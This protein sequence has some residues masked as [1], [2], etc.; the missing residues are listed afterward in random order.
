M[1]GMRPGVRFKLWSPK[2]TNRPDIE[3]PALLQFLGT[4]SILSAF[5]FLVFAVAIVIVPYG[6]NFEPEPL[7]ALYVATL[8]F[9]LPIGIFYT[10]MV[11]SPLS[12]WVISIHTVVLG[13][14]TIAGEGFLGQLEISETTRISASGAIMAIVLGW[15][16]GSPKMRFYYA[17]ISGKPIPEDLRSR[18]DELRGGVRLN[19]RFRAALEWFID[20]VEIAVMLGFIILVFYAYWETL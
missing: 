15:L 5:G 2:F 1:A 12:R 4:F 8:H 7:E 14:A 3:P 9:I 10:V 6:T 17:V 16:Y 18:A 13:A 19:S 11:N 20:R